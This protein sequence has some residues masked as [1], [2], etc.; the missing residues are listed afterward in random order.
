MLISVGVAAAIVLI[1]VVSVL[2]G[3]PATNSP[4]NVLVGKNVKGFT[5]AG[6]N[7]GKNRAPWGAGHAGVFIFF[8]SYCGPCKNEMPQIAPCTRTHSPSPVEVIAVDADDKV[9]PAKS[10][11]KKD[12]V[13]FPVASDPNGNV[14][15]GIFGFGAVPESVF[16][17]AQGVVTQVYIGAIPKKQLASCIVK[18]KSA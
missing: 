6:L 1:T 9:S 4:T 10:M 7:G 11:I 18:L 5:L 17:N 2:T 3:G 15:T 16:V 13:T 12:D 14:T 8:S